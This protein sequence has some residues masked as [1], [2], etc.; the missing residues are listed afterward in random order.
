[1]I[2]GAKLVDQIQ[3]RVGFAV[4]PAGPYSSMSTAQWVT[5]GPD[6]KANA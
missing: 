5:I 2:T 6:G 4:L 1:M 3:Q